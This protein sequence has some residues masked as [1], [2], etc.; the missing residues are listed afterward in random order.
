MDE[1]ALARPSDPGDDDECPERDVDVDTLEVVHRRAADLQGIRGR[2]NR[3][4]QCRPVVQ[5]AAGHGFALAKLLHGALKADRAAVRAR[6]RAEVDDV[7]GDRNRLRLVLDDKHRVALVPQL[8]QQVVHPLDVVR[9]QPNRGLVK[10]VGHVGERRAE[11]TDDLDPLRLATRQRARRPVERQVAQPDLHE[12]IQRLAQ[13][14]QERRDRRLIETTDPFGQVGDLHRTGVGDAELLDLHRP[15]PLAE[16]GAV[17]VRTGGERHRPVDEGSDVRLHRLPVLGQHRLLYP[18]NQPLV[19]HVDARDLHP[20]RFVM[21]ERVQLLPRELANRFVRVEEARGRV[22]AVVPAPRLIPRDR[23]RPLGERLGVVEQLTQIHV[24]DR[25]PTLAAR[26][27]AA[28]PAET[29]LHRLAVTALDRDPAAG[30]DRWNVEGEGAGW[31][32]MRLPQ[33]AEQD[34]Q[35]RVRVR[36]RADG[37]AGI[38]TDSLLVDADRGR[39]PLQQIDLGPAQRGHE[40]LNEGAVRLIDQ[41][42]GLGGD[43]VEHQRALART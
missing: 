1:R 20:G 13:G 26:A 15:S 10:D 29:R 8:E 28:G 7:V 4:L 17:A 35:H 36:G 39:Q 30:P 27:H 37:R 25:A 12:R 11:V 40:P 41:A 34:A 24:R 9:V 3:L 16:P 19:G 43:R 18:R 32:D 2:P 6:A 33:P 22:Q 23:H 42:L 14:R 31:A 38:S 5:V 21:E